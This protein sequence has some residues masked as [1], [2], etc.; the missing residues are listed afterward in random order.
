MRLRLLILVLGAMLSVASAAQPPQYKS[1]IADTNDDGP[2]WHGVAYTPMHVRAPML[3]RDDLYASVVRALAAVDVGVIREKDAV[4]GVVVTG[5]DTVFVDR[6]FSRPQTHQHAV[7]FT[8]D[9]GAV[10][11]DNVA[12]MILAEAED[13]NS[14]RKPTSQPTTQPDGSK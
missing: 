5:W 13:R 1:I 9:P 3:T 10:R 4:A 7:R 12:R 8:I 6:T 14:A 11:I 2:P